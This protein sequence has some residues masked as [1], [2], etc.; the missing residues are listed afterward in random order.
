MP[1]ATDFAKLMTVPNQKY[2][3][4]DEPNPIRRLF[5]AIA[6]QAVRD[7]FDP[8]RTLSSLDYELARKFL[9][10]EEIEQDL[11]DAGIEIPWG[12]IRQT[13]HQLSTNG[14]Q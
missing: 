9:F 11:T 10:D 12:T 2:G 14:G 1:T 6:L 4:A 13:Y 5:A 3:P 8:P 7:M